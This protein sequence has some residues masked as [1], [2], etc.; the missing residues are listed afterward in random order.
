MRFSR[1]AMTFVG[2]SALVLGTRWNVAAQ[3]PAGATAKCGDGTYSKS[4]TE[5]GACSKHKGV[6]EWYGAGGNAAAPQAPAA[7]APSA[8][9]AGATFACKDGSYS[10]SKS[11]KGACSKHGG[12][13]HALT[14]GQAPAAESAPAGA[15]EATPSA[16]KAPMAAR[17]SDAP[18]NA[19]AK[20]KDGTYSESKQHSGACSHHGGVVEWYK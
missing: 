4:K 19:T 8:A 6:V 2:V 1:A 11:A 16:G 17:P 20:C 3:A 9:P 12:I 7:A 5:K 18:A 14:G 10:K 15:S 13:D